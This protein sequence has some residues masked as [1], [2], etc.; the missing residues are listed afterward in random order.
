MVP[1]TVKVSYYQTEGQNAFTPGRQPFVLQGSV[2]HCKFCSGDTR[3]AQPD[4]NTLG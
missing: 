2:S 4:E 1:P 3:L